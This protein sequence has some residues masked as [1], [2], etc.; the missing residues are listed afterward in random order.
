MEALVKMYH[1]QKLQL[2]LILW[3]F[4]CLFF[5][6]ISVLII[7]VETRTLKDIGTENDKHLFL[8]YN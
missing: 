3:G 6:I 7:G 1:Q 5:K 4:V 2:V 8:Y